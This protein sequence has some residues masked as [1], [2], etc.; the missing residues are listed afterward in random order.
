MSAAASAAA[1]EIIEKLR[2][3]TDRTQVL[4]ADFDLKGVGSEDA[5][6]RI[7]SSSLTAPRLAPYLDTALKRQ[8]DAAESKAKRTSKKEKPI[9]FFDIDDDAKDKHAHMH[10]AMPRR[11]YECGGAILFNENFDSNTYAPAGTCTENRMVCFAL[12]TTW[13][14]SAMYP[15]D[16]S[17]IGTTPEEQNTKRIVHVDQK[18]YL[19]G[20]PR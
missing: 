10:V 8:E 9:R 14:T 18:I 16:A 2:T 15:S 4:Q 5:T 20:L 6:S 19:T 1:D 7:A 17:L 3:L 11:C 13:L 12:S